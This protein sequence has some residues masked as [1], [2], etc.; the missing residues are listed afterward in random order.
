MA[1]TK[2]EATWDNTLTHH[3]LP[4][5]VFIEKAFLFNFSRFGPVWP[6]DCGINV[7]ATVTNHYFLL[8]K[9]NF[10]ACNHFGLSVDITLNQWI[11]VFTCSICERLF[12]QHVNRSEGENMAELA[13]HDSHCWT[14]SVCVFPLI[15]DVWAA[16]ALGGSVTGIKRTTYVSPIKMN[17]CTTC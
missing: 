4:V 7:S 13:K 12:L 16:W 5:W 10:D 8:L 2:I 1:L 14:L 11:R 3:H 15:T 9:L 6:L 17:Q